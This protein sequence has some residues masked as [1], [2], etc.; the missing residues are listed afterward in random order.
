MDCLPFLKVLTVAYLFVSFCLSRLLSPFPS[1]FIVYPLILPFRIHSLLYHVFLSFLFFS[2]FLACF[3]FLF[4]SFCFSFFLSY[5]NSFI[6]SFFYLSL[7]NKLH[8]V[9]FHARVRRF[10]PFCIRGVWPLLY[11]WSVTMA[12][13]SF[14]LHL[15]SS[16]SSCPRLSRVP[17]APLFR[18]FLC[19][20]C[21]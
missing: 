11:L 17:R 15:L 8:F 5:I 7:C 4:F 6:C 2:F 16:Y 12:L 1:C 10:S 14:W 18:V 13:I 21:P 9:L 3:S 20:T 19:S